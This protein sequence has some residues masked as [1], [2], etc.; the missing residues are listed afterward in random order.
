MD[1]S[2]VVLPLVVALLGGGGV[3]AIVSAFVTARTAARKSA[4]DGLDSLVRN[5][6]SDYDRLKAENV[7][8]RA[9]QERLEAENDQLRCELN[10]IRQEATEM[11]RKYNR[12]LVWARKQGYTPPE[13]KGG[14]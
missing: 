1:W 4:L 10:T 6:Q 14:E 13:H 7:E 9:A 2:T 3:G 5:L 8:L 12:V 11:R